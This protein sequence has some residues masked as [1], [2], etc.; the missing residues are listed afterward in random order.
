MEPEGLLVCSEDPATG[1]CLSFILPVKFCVRKEKVCIYAGYAVP[2]GLHS[3][4][5]KKATPTKTNNI[6]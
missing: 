5:V 2:F 6:V 3:S 1:P 4:K